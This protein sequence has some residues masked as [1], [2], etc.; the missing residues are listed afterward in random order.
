MAVNHPPQFEGESPMLHTKNIRPNPAGD[1][2]RIHPGAYVDPSA[3]IIGHVSIE[4]GVFIGPLSVIRADER[5]TDGK[6]QPILIGQDVNIQD[7]VIIH[8]YGGS[9]VT[10]GPS[11]SIAHGVVIHGP[12]HID[13]GCFLSMRCTIYSATL[14]AGVWI[15]MGAVVMRATLAAHTY[16]PPGSIIRNNAGAMGMYFVN[17]KEQI[18][19]DKALKA[20]QRI[21]QD[22][23]ARSEDAV[24]TDP[25]EI[26]QKDG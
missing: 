16:V 4:Q 7:G 8:S 13:E 10:I 2:P 17:M 19:M 23:R 26:K 24:D 3:Q 21:Y 18:Y 22:Y 6:V 12:C 14:E 9:S 11:T 1:T 15:G 20:A 25:E 5:G